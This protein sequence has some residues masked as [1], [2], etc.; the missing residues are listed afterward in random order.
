MNL[1]NVIIVI[2]LLIIVG[3][4]AYQL[5]QGAM[6]E[7]TSPINSSGS[8]A[9]PEISTN[10]TFSQPSPTSNPVL[11]G[12]VTGKLC[13]PSSFLPKGN[14]EAKN[15]NNQQV[16]SQDYQGTENGGET[17]YTIELPEGEYHLRYKVSTELNGYHTTVCLTGTETSCADTEKRIIA[18]AVV[19][20]N[21]TTTQHDLCDFYHNPSNAPDF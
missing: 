9:T 18:S 6:K 11:N 3:G 20:P 2:L 12:T 13:Y 19:K 15:I 14:I 10:D 17:N 5:G 8:S 16:Y 4:G 21:Q 7:N 1:K